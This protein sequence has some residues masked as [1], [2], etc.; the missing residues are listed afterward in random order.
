MHD[1]WRSVLAASGLALLLLVGSIVFWPVIP[2]DETRYVS[3]AWEMHQRGDF[4]VP[5][6][7]GAPYSDKP[8]LLF[9]LMNAG[10]SV[11]GVNAWW[12]RAVSAVF[13]V[14]STLLIAQMA[15]RLWPGVRGIEIGRAS[16]RERVLFEV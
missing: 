14:L 6:L 2:L 15:L 5:Y 11:F 1:P 13:A 8:P 7:N 9:W 4:L 10:W 3:V 16:C 12:P